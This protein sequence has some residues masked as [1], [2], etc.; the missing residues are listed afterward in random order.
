MVTKNVKINEPYYGTLHLH[1]RISWSAILIGALVGIGLTFLLNLFCVAIGVS[2]F[3]VGN[4]GAIALVVDG[5]VSMLVGIIAA[6]VAAGY[7]AGYLGRFLCPQRNL[8]ILYGF[9]TWTVAILLSAAVSAYVSSYVTTYTNTISH[10]SLVV[11]GNNSHSAASLIIKSTHSMN[12][13]NHQTIKATASANTLAWCAFSVFALFFI[14]AIAS[15]IGA[16]W[17]MSCTRQD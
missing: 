9:T 6:M 10:S 8:G 11:P 17:G 2:V 3:T 15:C 12:D 5:I 7:A 13:T 14:G 1:N 4:D 16:C